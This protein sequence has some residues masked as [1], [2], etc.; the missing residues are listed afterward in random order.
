MRGL[1]LAFLLEA[2][3]LHREEGRVIAF[4]GDTLAAVELENPA[5]HVVEEVAVVG[6]E[7]DAAFVFAQRVFKPGN[8][9]RVEMVGGFVE[10]QDIGGLE[11]QFAQGHAAAFA[12]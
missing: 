12:A 3:F 1:F 4:V 6:D 10:Q 11:Q 8:R 7:D 2:L 5:R 9:L